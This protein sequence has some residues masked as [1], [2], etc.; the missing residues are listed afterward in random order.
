MN[1]NL[2]QF[3]ERWSRSH[4]RTTAAGLAVLT[5]VIVIVELMSTDA[6]IVLYQAF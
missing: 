6:P 3:F 1:N 2:P 4:P 5:L